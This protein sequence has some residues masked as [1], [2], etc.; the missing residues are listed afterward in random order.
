M[1][2]RLLIVYNPTSGRARARA[3]WKLLARLLSD[4]SPE[5]LNIRT[6]RQLLRSKFSSCDIVVAAGGD[7]TVREVIQ[8]LAESRKK[9]LLAILPTG[10]GNVLARS[11]HLPP[12]PRALARLIRNGTS[13]SI[14][15][16]RLDTGEYFAVACALGYLSERVGATRQRAKRILGFAGYLWSFL[17][18]HRVPQYQFS[19][20][21]G[22]MSYE[23]TGH[24]VFILNASNLFGVHSRNVE[25][26]HDGLFEL[27]VAKNRSLF[28][29]PRLVHD[30]YFK[31]K[32]PARFS[33]LRGNDFSVGCS[34]S[35]PLVLD[36]ETFQS[37]K[38]IRLTV[39]PGAQRIIVAK[40][41]SDYQR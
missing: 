28:S 12:S 31:R 24:S 19:I 1:S 32:A 3:S 18:R 40:V 27:T 7:G 2:G 26:L 39:L 6:E 10:S 8:E 38:K 17:L 21:T 20:H 14:D 4:F 16:A 35:L 15:L 25:S 33:L 9:I 37:R 41:Y 13:V 29:F 11:L 30:F 23:E 34:E 22:N 36:G 5:L